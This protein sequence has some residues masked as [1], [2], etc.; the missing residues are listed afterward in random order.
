MRLND[1]QMKKFQSIEKIFIDLKK[2]EEMY[3]VWKYYSEYY[4]TIEPKKQIITFLICVKLNHI[5]T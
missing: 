3:E 5:F 1:I 4:N 2:K